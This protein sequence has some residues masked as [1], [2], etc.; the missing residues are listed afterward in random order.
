ML[1]V[2]ATTLIAFLCAAPDTLLDLPHFLNAF[3]YLASQYRTPLAGA[4]PVWMREIK[5]LR[6]ALG[7][8]G[9]VIILTGLAAGIVRAVTGPGRI[10]WVLATTFPIM[11]FAFVARQN[12]F[13]AR[14]LLPLVPALALLGAAGIVWIVDFARRIA[15]P[16]PVRQLVIVAATV[17]SIVPPTYTSIG[18]NANQSLVWTTEQ[19]YWWVLRTLPPGTHVAIEGSVTFGLPAT[20]DAVRP[21]QLRRKDAAIYKREGVQYLVASSQVYGPYVASPN[22]YPEENADYQ[23]LFSETREVIR[24]SPSPEHPG[25]E[26]RVLEVK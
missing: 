13:F 25:P 9:S 16:A 10:K 18:F 5:S 2:A 3:A 6:I 15:L 26:L 8:P 24:F 20:Y 21:I 19:A 22:E 23:R 1:W 12:I 11:Y 7:W 4:D 17:L 14:Y